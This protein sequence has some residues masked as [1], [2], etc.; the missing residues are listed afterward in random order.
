MT[1]CL[2]EVPP[3]SRNNV[4]SGAYAATFRKVAVDGGTHVLELGISQY[5]AGEISDV[6]RLAFIP[7][8]GAGESE[9]AAARAWYR[10][11]HMASGWV[12]TQAKVHSIDDLVQP[13]AART[14][15]PTLFQGLLA[16]LRLR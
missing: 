16:A 1:M 11:T 12:V 4:V 6:F 7:L 15:N 8:T 5:S 3:A 10:S 14:G 13:L 2:L 9:S